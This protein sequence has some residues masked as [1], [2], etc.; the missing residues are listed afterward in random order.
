MNKFLVKPILIKGDVFGDRFGWA[1]Y[2]YHF[3]LGWKPYKFNI[4]VSKTNTY[5]PKKWNEYD[6]YESAVNS[7]P[8]TSKTVLITKWMKLKN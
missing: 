6:T 2:K 5:K 3:L 7:I 1:V 4:T 8:K